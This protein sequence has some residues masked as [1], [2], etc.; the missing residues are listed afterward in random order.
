MWL[1]PTASLYMAYEEF[2]NIALMFY[3]EGCY[4][5]SIPMLCHHKV[6]ATLFLSICIQLFHFYSLTIFVGRTDLTKLQVRKR[7]SEISKDFS[8]NT[9]HLLNKNCNHFTQAVC[10]DLV[11]KENLPGWINRL[12]TVTSYV[13]F[14]GRVLPTSWLVPWAPQA[15]D[16]Q[17]ESQPVSHESATSRSKSYTEKSYVV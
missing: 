10:K 15:N 12:A 14:I 11:G 7:I 16:P 8:G 17:E 6:V 9:Y 5:V 2:N 1:L 13:P 4:T 3:K